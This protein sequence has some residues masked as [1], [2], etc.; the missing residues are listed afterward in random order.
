MYISETV[1]SFLAH[2]PELSLSIPHER[3]IH[4]LREII[5]S[6][7]D[8]NIAAFSRSLGLPKTTAWE[9]IQGHFPPSLPFLLQLCYQFRLSLLQLLI[10]DRAYQCSRTAYIAR[11]NPK[12]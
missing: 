4:S 6:T 5:E 12:T 1:G 10:S 3:V 8:G 11:T 2:I 7:T 9:L